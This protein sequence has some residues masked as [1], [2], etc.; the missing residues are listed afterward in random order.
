[1]AK[2]S[3]PLFKFIRNCVR[4]QLALYA[5]QSSFFM[6]FS[7]IPIIMIIIFVVQA[8]LPF[9][10]EDYIEMIMNLFPAG[11]DL[12]IPRIV[13]NLLSYS[14]RTIIS[15]SAITLLWSASKVVYALMLGLNHVHHT[16]ETRKNLIRRFVAIFYTLVFV[17]I[18]IFY[19][20]VLVFGDYIQM[21]LEKL[22]PALT[23]S[24]FLIVCLRTGISILIL[25]LFFTLIYKT[26]PDKK[27]NFRGQLPGAIFATAGW[28]IYSY[29]FT[30]YINNF[31]HYS[32][33]YGSL[34][35]IILFMLWIYFCMIILL[36][37]AELNIVLEDNKNE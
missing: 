29:L 9:T 24:S 15:I 10:R 5:A 13:N 18:I 36:A 23:E 7:L 12:D 11:I 8:F 1:M 21:Y 4:D 17:L 30:I 26:L 28:L 32:Y 34:T 3:K 35:A 20:I 2:K 19:F 16:V 27:L 6:M 25:V 33:I 37:G 31:S 22:I 14:A